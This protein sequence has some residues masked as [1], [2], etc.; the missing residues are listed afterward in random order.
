MVEVIDNNFFVVRF[1]E[2]YVT[3]WR[4]YKLYFTKKLDEK[5]FIHTSLL[6]YTKTRLKKLLRKE[7]VIRHDDYI[8]LYENMEIISANKISTYNLVF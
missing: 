2:Y 1:G 3:L 5:C 7:L 6:E 4:N 8:V